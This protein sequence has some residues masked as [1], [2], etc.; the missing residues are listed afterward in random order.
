MNRPASLLHSLAIRKNRVLYLLSLSCCL[1]LRSSCFFISE[2]WRAS[3]SVLCSNLTFIPHTKHTHTHNSIWRMRVM[4]QTW[5]KLLIVFHSPSQVVGSRRQPSSL[6]SPS[7][8][9]IQPPMYLQCTVQ[10]IE[11][12]ETKHVY[13][14]K[15]NVRCSKSEC[16]RPR[17][18]S[19]FQ[20]AAWHVV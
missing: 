16:N 9:C 1:L 6:P 14:H 19:W 11:H 10:Y 20:C 17:V 13:T 12:Q 4:I 5:Q 18:W 15:L 2:L 8:C 3:S 7:A